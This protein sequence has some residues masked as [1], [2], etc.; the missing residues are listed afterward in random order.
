[1]LEILIFSFLV[2]LTGALLPG[3]LLNYI[4][5]KSMKEKKG[6]ILTFFILLGHATIELAF[7]LILLSGVS[8]FFNNIYVLTIIGIVGG[9][10]LI[11]FG[12]FSIKDALKIDQNSE[13]FESPDN[14]NHYKGNSFIGGIVVTLSNPGWEIWWA[15][16]GLGFMA[17]FNITFFNPIGLILFFIGHELGDIIWYLPVSVSVSFGRKL[18]NTKIYKYVLVLCGIFMIGF[19]FYLALNIIFFPPIS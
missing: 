11:L 13:L 4:I 12:I 18:F 3:P 19:G 14:Y 5:Y 8:F 1:M 9:S 17:D 6:Y 10:L 7:I 15:S 2:A 16:T